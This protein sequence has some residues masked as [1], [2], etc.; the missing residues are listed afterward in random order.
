[1]GSC[2]A[3]DWVLLRSRNQNFGT[4]VVEAEALAC[5]CDA[6]LSDRTRLVVSLRS[7]PGVLAVERSQRAFVRLIQ[8]AFQLHGTGIFEDNWVKERFP[9]RLIAC[10]ALHVYSSVLSHG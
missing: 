6:L 8:L 2:N 10:S 9:K 5:G 3:S 1:M 7:R 4:V